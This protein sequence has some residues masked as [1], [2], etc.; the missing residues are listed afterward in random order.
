[1]Q[2]E[3]T[4]SRRG[5]VLGGLVFCGTP[6]LIGAGLIAAAVG[7]NV[8]ALPPVPEPPENRVTEAKRVLGKILFWEEQLSSDNMV[9]CGTCHTPGAG[10]ADTRRVRQPGPD[11]ILNT[12]D[13]IFGSPGVVKSDEL[14]NYELDGIFGLNAQV[15]GRGS[16]T[17]ILAAYAPTNFWD[18]RAGGRFVDPETGA[19]LIQIGGALEN[20]AVGPVL[21]D[22]E[23]AHADRD[24]AAVSAKLATAQPLALATDL[25]PDMAQA[26][27][28]GVDYPELFRRAFGDDAISAA[29]IAF[30]IATY[31]RTLIA[32]QTPWD[33]FDAGDTNALTPQQRA[34]LQTFQGAR[35]AT[36]H[37]APVFSDHSFRNIGLRPVAED[38]GRQIV[39]GNPADRGRFKVPTLRNVGRK[40]SFMHNGQFNTLT[41]VVRFYARAPGS[42]PQFRDNLD[43]VMDQ[44]RFPPQQEAGLI[45]FLAN[46]LLDPRVRD[47]VF[48]FD[49]PTLYSVRTADQPA[50][51]GGGR[52]GTGGFTPAMVTSAPP[53]VGNSEF[54]FGVR[55]ARPGST[56]VL[57]ISHTPPVG[58]V[59][60]TETQLGPVTTAGTGNGGGYATIHW[61]IPADAALDGTTIYT[62]WAITDAA[63]AG[64]IALSPVVRY[65]FFCGGVGCPTSC[66]ADWDRS[67]G[68]DGDDIGAFFTDWQRGEADIDFSGGTDGDDI[69]Y[70]FARWQ[71]GC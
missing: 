15:T 68:V 62:Q 1:M 29:R 7:F 31:E 52:A 24:W 59:I 69:S 30:A 43:P 19:M 12:P 41:G 37:D 35:C 50:S 11:G 66:P 46:G 54:R 53:F 32:D 47:R 23:M 28:G 60:A 36:C 57:H 5:A 4:G 51:L 64:G 3:R 6:V 21:N 9:S 34:G 16:Q 70:F 13:D 39:T 49:H 14:G 38:L 71:A 45:D 40:T 10:G 63:A 18:G 27:E 33:R 65:T 2:S 22:V 44:V 48:P 42:P 25:P 8:A 61:P 58:G 20:Q 67:G 55:A 17:A 56:A 26:I